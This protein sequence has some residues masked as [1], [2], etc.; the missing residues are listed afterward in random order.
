MS[1]STRRVLL[2]VLTLL[3]LLVGQPSLADPARPTHFRSTVQGVVDAAG[4]PVQGVSAEV[5]GG[6]AYL[7]LTL[8]P[9]RRVEVPGY[10][11]EP[12]LRF[13]ADGQV[14]V[15]T[16]SP[17]RWLND[18]RFGALEV[19][20]P[21]SADAEA[22]PQWETVA[23]GGRYAWHDHRVHFMSPT[24]PGDVDP[25]AGTSQRVFAWEVPLLVDGSDARIE[26]ELLWIPGP[27]L[28]VPIT[29]LVLTLA[30]A[31]GLA[32]LAPRARAVGVLV[33]AGL[34]LATGVI[35][36]I[37]APPGGDTEPALTVL[38]V[39]SLG[40]WLLS[41]VRF[42]NAAGRDRVRE[43]AALPLLGWG[44][45]WLTTWWRPIAPVGLPI[46]LVRVVV[47][48]ALVVGVAGVITLLRGA[49]DAISLERAPGGP[50]GRA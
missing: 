26:G 49:L 23:T 15:N 40:V 47:A 48:G 22:L 46:G 2:G 33:G 8:A 41:R 39:A 20:V 43:A 38:P 12:Y 9:G 17:A 44:L 14:A 6:D 24:L 16:R 42:G 37:E 27:S 29:L 3:V 45:W 1:A 13:A 4:G 32:G 11:G 25:A 36:T 19:E 31:V 50:R 28:A 7:V 35:A 30:G 34:A 21:A 10:E 18:A 5:V